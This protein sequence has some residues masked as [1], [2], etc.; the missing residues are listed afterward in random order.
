M[1]GNARI[2]LASR[3]SGN[4]TLQNFR[5]ETVAL[6]ALADGQ[7]L[8]RNLL[9][10]LDPYMRPRMSEL[11]SY[12]PPFE[13]GAVLTG[14]VVAEVI[15]SKNPRYQPGEH[16]MG[17]LGWEQHSLS[18]GRALRKLDPGAAPL[19]AH[20]GVLGMPG[21]TAY[22]GMLRICQPKEGETVFVSAATGA[23]GAVA[24]QLAKL[25]GARRG[26]RLDRREMRFRGQGTGLR[27][28]FQPHQAPRLRRGA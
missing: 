10:S 14:G 18:D 7:I 25:K 17:M 24:G 2:V 13:L 6:P 3:P 16:V 21:Y 11:R 15:D 9:L 19:A 8:T 20:L 22:H 23:V 5:V 27:R 12:T 4:V 1:T 28:L 26:L